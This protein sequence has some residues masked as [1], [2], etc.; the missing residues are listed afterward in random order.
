MEGGDKY[1][2]GAE[3]KDADAA[4]LGVPWLVGVGQRMNFQRGGEHKD[5]DL[6]MQARVIDLV[7]KKKMKVCYGTKNRGR[8][9]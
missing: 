9:M 7:M 2:A 6:G 4:D 5:A 3:H 8:E 1:P